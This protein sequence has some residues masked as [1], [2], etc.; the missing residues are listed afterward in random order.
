[1]KISLKKLATFWRLPVRDKLFLLRAAALALFIRLFLKIGSFKKLT[2]LLK[3]SPILTAP[4]NEIAVLKYHRNMILM[5]YNLHPLIN[6]LAISVAFW[7]LLK[8]KGIKTELKFGAMK[9]AG[10][11]KAHAWLEHEGF[12]LAPDDKIS[13]YK[14][15]SSPIL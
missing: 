15:F 8:R 5:M 9:E 10:K 12:P 1:L 3:V 4:E 2:G 14:T 13:L 7:Y 11:L 6:C